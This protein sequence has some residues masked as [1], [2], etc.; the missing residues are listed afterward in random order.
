MPKPDAPWLGAHMSIAGGIPLSV[1]RARRVR[2]N[3]LQIFVK[4]NN[5]WQ[6]REFSDEEADDFRRACRRARLRRVV[7]HSSYLINLASP[8]PALW[9]RSIEATVD[10]L[11]RCRRLGVSHLVVHPGAHVGSG[12]GP[13]VKRVAAAL[14]RVFERRRQ[15]PVKLALETT[16]GQGTSLGYRFSQLRDILAACETPERV[17]F[18]LDTCHAFAAGYDLRSP[19]GYRRMLREFERSV[20]LERLQVLHLNDSKRELGSRVDRHEHIGEGLIGRQAF[21][22]ILAD[23]RLARVPKILETPKGKDLKEDRRNLNLLRRLH[24]DGSG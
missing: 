20:G 11:D 8:D 7:A 23:R 3:V 9:R 16:A 4:N 18:C 24:R 1:G 22:S 10:E 12:E 2:A 13:G 14:D 19:A 21:A 17:A 5:R 6:G 15:C